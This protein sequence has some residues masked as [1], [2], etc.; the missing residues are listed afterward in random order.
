MIHDM[1]LLFFIPFL[2]KYLG[3][4]VAQVDS[5]TNFSPTKKPQSPFSRQQIAVF[6][7]CSG[8]YLHP[9]GEEDYTFGVEVLAFLA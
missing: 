2:S 7:G 5:E 8:I 3:G 4:A 9:T 6:Q 1:K